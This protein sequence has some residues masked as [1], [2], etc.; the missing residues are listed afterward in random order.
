MMGLE[1]FIARRCVQT[2]V[3]WTPDGEDG[4]GNT[5]FTSDSPR[6]IACRWEDS[7]RLMT[8]A[9]GDEIVV[10]AEVFVTE[11]LEEKGV[12]YLGTLDDL[13][14]AQEDDPKQVDGAYE[15]RRFD[16]M[17]ELGSATK[18]LRKAYLTIWQR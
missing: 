2:A 10:R 14:S 16:K 13:D 7:T 3:Y 8:D 17:P 9:Q 18:F 5:V 6:E 1:A 12:L 11:D 4:Y 15:I